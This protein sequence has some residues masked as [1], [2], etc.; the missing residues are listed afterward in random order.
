MAVAEFPTAPAGEIRIPALAAAVTPARVYFSVL[1][2][3]GLAAF[4]FGV[5]NRFSTE[6]LLP[7]APPVDWIPPLS[8]RTWS[9][10]FTIHQQDP[11]FAACGSAV[12]LAQFKILYW[13]EWLRQASL[14]ALAVGATVGLYGAGVWRRFRYMLPRLGGLACLV[15]AYW[16]ARPLAELAVNAAATLSSF[17][18]GQY[19]HAVDLTFASIALAGVFASAARPP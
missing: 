4:V 16:A 12:T 18:T 19:R 17:N 8:A 1:S 7:V 14:V 13:W 6:N 9:A 3:L 10:A 15:F 11:L 2:L 5:D